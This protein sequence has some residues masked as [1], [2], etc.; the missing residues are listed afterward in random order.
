[1]AK[2]KGTPLWDKDRQARAKKANN[3]IQ[4]EKKLTGYERDKNFSAY[5]ER[6]NT[7]DRILKAFNRNSKRKD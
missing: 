7:K 3:Q 6:G 5:M 2:L 1:M 4:L